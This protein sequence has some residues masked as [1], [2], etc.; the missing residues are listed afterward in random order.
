MDNYIELLCAVLGFGSAVLVF[1]TREGFVKKKEAK[2]YREYLRDGQSY[3]DAL[4]KVRLN[5]DDIKKI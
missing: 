5:R 2:K 1:L 3:L 4:A